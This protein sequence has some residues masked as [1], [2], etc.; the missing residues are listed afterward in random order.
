MADGKYDEYVKESEEEDPKVTLKKVI[1]LIASM[2]PNRPMPQ[3]APHTP[4]LEYPLDQYLYSP[5][6]VCGYFYNPETGETVPPSGWDPETK[7]PDWDVNSSKVL[8]TSSIDYDATSAAEITI[9]YDAYNRESTEINGESFPQ[10]SGGYYAGSIGSIGGGDIS[11]G[12][13]EPDDKMPTAIAEYLDMVVSRP[14]DPIKLDLIPSSLNEFYLFYNGRLLY[15]NSDYVIETDGKISFT[16]AELQYGDKI[17]AFENLAADKGCMKSR[18]REVI[19][20]ATKT[21][22]CEDLH[23]NS[24][25]LPFYD[26]ELVFQNNYEVQEGRVR[27]VSVLEEGKH[28]DITECLF[29]EDSVLEVAFAGSSSTSSS[30]LSVRGVRKENCYLVFYDGKFMMENVDY[31]LQKNTIVFLNGLILDVNKKILVLRV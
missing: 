24:Y 11:G 21:I 27:F 23:T 30:Y 19:P 3:N 31:M 9:S 12:P 2:N 20:T 10:Q 8:L 17:Y 22:E 25:I 13:E 5:I 26:G 28:L 15:P 1:R 18:V 14:H 4:T 16:A 7:G 29:A 6:K